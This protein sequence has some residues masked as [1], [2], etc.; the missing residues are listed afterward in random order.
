[1]RNIFL[2]TM[3]LLLGLMASAHTSFPKDD[4]KRLRKLIT[5]KKM[6]TPLPVLMSDDQVCIDEL[7]DMYRWDVQTAKLKA[8]SIQKRHEENKFI[9]EHE[10][11]AGSSLLKS[12]KYHAVVRQIEREELRY[13]L[14]ERE[15]RIMANDR[16]A[17]QR[18]EPKG[19]LLSVT[20]DSSGMSFNPD[21]PFTITKMDGDSA[22]VTYSFKD[23]TFKVDGKYL[24]MMQEAIISEHLYQLHDNYD[25][26][27]WDLP[28][29]PRIQMLDGQRWM[30]E[31]K[32]SDGTV[33]SSSGMVPPAQNVE[34]I[35]KIYF[36]SVFPN[37]AAYKK[38]VAE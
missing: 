21:L 37:S 30:F 9:Q 7:Y 18:P 25:F 10:N 3:A 23:F 31:A 27:D 1:M 24:S 16:A 5:Q 14:Y 11:W 34:V 35:P 6:R 32:F 28:D 22:L 15:C 20:Y 29:V 4:V 12:G 26:K 13:D 19:E 2:M 33:I 38:R 8:D 17:E 36:D